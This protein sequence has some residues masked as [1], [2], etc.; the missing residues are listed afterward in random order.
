MP[1]MTT[2]A[3]FDLAQSFGWDHGIHKKPSEAKK[4]YIA[5]GVFTLL[6]MGLNFF[7]YQSDEG[8]RVCWNRAGM[9]DAIPDAAGHAHHEQSQDHGQMG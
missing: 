7:G 2:G 6:A 9:F 8:A 4:I 3:A 5:I 1:V